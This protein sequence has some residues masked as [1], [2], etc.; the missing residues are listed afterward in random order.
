M[1]RAAKHDG[2]VSLCYSLL[3]PVFNILK[4][5]CGKL[6]ASTFVYPDAIHSQP[7]IACIAANKYRVAR[8]NI[9]I[10]LSSKRDL[11]TPITFY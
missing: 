3:G 4:S 5:D 11:Q 6:P 9:V 10:I 8:F 7:T 1:L 2:L